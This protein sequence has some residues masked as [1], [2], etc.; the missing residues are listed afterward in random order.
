MEVTAKY[1]YE[2]AADDELSFRVGDCLKILQT[3][4]NWYKAEL[5]G[6]EG[7]VPKNF[8]NIDFPS[9]YQ[10]DASRSDAKKLLISQ[11]TGTFIIRRSRDEDAGS[12]SI[13]VRNAKDVQHLK[14]LRDTRGQYYL[15]TEK[16]PS[17][18]QLVEFYK[19]NSVS[20][21]DTIFLQETQ[22]QQRRRPDRSP[23]LPPP[24]PPN[25]SAIDPRRPPP[26]PR[27]VIAIY[28]FQAKEKDE[29]EFHAGDIIAVLDSSDQVWWKGQLRG[30]TGLF[31]CNYTKPM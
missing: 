8:I 18:N 13:S 30:K 5:N 6:V 15:W 20:K 1:C 14:V 11:P 31:P 26:P 10:E 9:W 12:F 21:Q 29:L 24:T 3:S 17:V 16:F 7:F 23:S 4:G 22:Q 25:P 19:K 27:P 28:N 2:A